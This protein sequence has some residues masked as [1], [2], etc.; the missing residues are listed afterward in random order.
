M[1]NN[2]DPLTP[3]TSTLAPAISHIA[4]TA[5]ALAGSL[6]D[7]SVRPSANNS[8]EDPVV[9]SKKQ[10]QAT[11]RWVLSTP[12]R[13]Q[14][15]LE[16]GNLADAINDWREVGMLLQ[17]WEGVAGVSELKNA[18]LQVLGQDSSEKAS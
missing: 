12:Q 10:Q 1:R 17:Q 5:R 14:T 7:R 16:A 4:E 3:T 6:Q 2:M 8:A 13:L 11:V 18:C 9:R 15:L